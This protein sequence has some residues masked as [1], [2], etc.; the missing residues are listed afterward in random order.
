[1]KSE[2]PFCSTEILYVA[3]ASNPSRKNNRSRS[4]W[5]LK[6]A[7]LEGEPV[8]AKK[9]GRFLKNDVRIGCM[10]TEKYHRNMCVCVCKYR[11]LY[12]YMYIHMGAVR[13]PRPIACDSADN[14]GVGNNARRTIWP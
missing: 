12:I 1:M 6:E 7:A 10:Y 3:V 5:N 9:G 13:I 8:A 2:L 14:I 4:Q 11:Y